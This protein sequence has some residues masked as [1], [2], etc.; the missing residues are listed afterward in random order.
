MGKETINLILF[1]LHCNKRITFAAEAKFGYTPTDT[2][3][4][5]EGWKTLLLQIDSIRNRVK[6]YSANAHH[7][8]SLRYTHYHNWNVWR[9]FSSDL[10]IFLQ[11]WAL[12][13]CLPTCSLYDLTKLYSTLE[14]MFILLGCV[15]C[16]NYLAWSLNFTLFHRGFHWQLDFFYR[17]RS[18]LS[19][20][21][22]GNPGAF[23]NTSVPV[24]G[25]IQNQFRDY[26]AL[27]SSLRLLWALWSSRGTWYVVVCP[28][29]SIT[30]NEVPL[31]LKHSLFNCME[32]RTSWPKD[33]LL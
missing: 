25:V 12:D 2:P 6:T 23:N 13:V 10:K 15:F 31:I 3:I 7:H 30:L 26:F 11:T 8:T 27:L 29:R 33:A 4:K 18:H 14:R 17:A 1:S 19:R 22:S 32:R 16:L 28:D 21:G 20:V 9:S 5:S 24:N